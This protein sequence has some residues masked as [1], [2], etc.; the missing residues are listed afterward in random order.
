MLSVFLVGEVTGAELPGKECDRGHPAAKLFAAQRGSDAAGAGK[1]EIHPQPL[2][3]QSEETILSFAFG[4]IGAEIASGNGRA[5]QKNCFGCVGA[6][7]AGDVEGKISPQGIQTA[8]KGVAV[9]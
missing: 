6:A 8:N 9:G 4:E 7:G 1:R 3:V 5:D 2:Y